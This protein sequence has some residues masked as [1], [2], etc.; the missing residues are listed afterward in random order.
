MVMDEEE[1]LGGFK[2]FISSDPEVMRRWWR[3]WGIR[4]GNAI[5]RWLSRRRI[6]R[7]TKVNTEALVAAYESLLYAYREAEKMN[8]QHNMAVYR[9]GLYLLTVS[10]DIASIKVDLLTSHDWW[11]RKLL[12]RNVALMIYEVD[13]HK[14]TGTKFRA[15]ID[16]F[17]PSKKFKMDLEDALS[18]LASVHA[19]VKSKL[20]DIRNYTIAHRDADAMKQH[21]LIRNINEVE[22]IRIAGEFFSAAN[23]IVPLLV[24]LIRESSGMHHPLNQYVGKKRFKNPNRKKSSAVR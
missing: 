12:A 2:R 19:D 11:L 6:I 1:K 15:A 14:V 5:G 10:R 21:R 24:E 3:I 4:N 8:L 23:P 7:D 20:A 16:F 13:M 9:V 18:N 17:S 22:V